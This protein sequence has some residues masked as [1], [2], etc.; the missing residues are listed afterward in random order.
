M[1]ILALIGIGIVIN[2]CVN[3]LFEF[4]KIRHKNLR[5]GLAFLTGL[6]VWYVQWTVTFQY[7]MIDA[8][9]S[10]MD[11]LSSLEWA[12]TDSDEKAILSVLYEMGYFEIKGNVVSGVFLSIIWLAEFLVFT[13]YPLFYAFTFEPKPY[14]DAFEKWYDH[15]VVDNT[16]RSLTKSQLVLQE[17]SNNPKEKIITKSLLLL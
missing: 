5:L 15:Y 11:S 1:N 10:I 6:L 14:S 8:V 17:L 9:P 7:L 16:F 2:F 3:R 4:F 13:G 12:F